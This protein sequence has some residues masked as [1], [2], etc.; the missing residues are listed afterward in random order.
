[1]PEE[2]PKLKAPYGSYKSVKNFV[3]QLAKTV[4]PPHIDRDMM[5]SMSGQTQSEVATALR[6]LRGTDKK[7]NTLAPLKKL[8]DSHGSDSWQKVLREIINAAYK[9]VV[10]QLDIA[11]SSAKQLQSAFRAYTN[12]D[13]FMLTRHVRFYLAAL[14]DA[15]VEYSPHFKAPKSPKRG[16][17]GA[18][19]QA[20]KKTAEPDSSEETRATDPKPARKG[21]RR[22]PILIPGKEEG[23]LEIP[24]DTTKAEFAAVESAV[25]Q[26]KV[27]VEL[28]SGE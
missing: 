13:G 14:K 12:A 19:R 23:I 8:V 24:E 9:P 27:F 2:T 5:S 11:S 7:G 16:G 25:A 6:F 28:L 15:G 21:M 22:V 3:G 20:A 4:Y 26:A 18:K 17:N 1:M 10:G